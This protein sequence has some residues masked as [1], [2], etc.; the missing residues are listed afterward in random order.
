[1][2]NVTLT[3]ETVG[4]TLTALGLVGALLV[5]VIRAVSNKGDQAN[6]LA[7]ARIEGKVDTMSTKVD[8]VEA[9]VDRVEYEVTHTN[10]GSTVKGKVAEN[11]KRI[12]VIAQ[13]ARVHTHQ[14][15][16]QDSGVDFVGP[17]DDV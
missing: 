15:N 7:L 8:G 4:L 14:S 1:M 10:D 9:K 17:G 11:A 2:G 12:D 5:W 13:W 16:Q 6:A 3:P